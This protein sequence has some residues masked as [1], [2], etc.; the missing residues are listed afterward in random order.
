MAL[1]SISQGFDGGF[2][3]GFGQ[4]LSGLATL[5]INMAVAD[6]QQRQQV[7]ASK[8]LAEH[9][10]Q[11][12]DELQKRRNM[13]S[14]G[15]L[16]AGARAAGLSPAAALGMTP[17]GSSVANGPMPSATTPQMQAPS[18]LEASQAA[19]TQSQARLN[20]AQAKRVEN[21]NLDTEIEWRTISENLPSFFREV[22]KTAGDRKGYF[23]NLADDIQ[24]NGTTTG[25]LR[26]Y[27]ESVVKLPEDIQA[28]LR[29]KGLNELELSKFKLLMSEQGKKLYSAY[30]RKDFDAQRKLYSDIKLIN[31]EIAANKGR[32][33]LMSDQGKEALAAAA[34]FLA[35]ANLI[36]SGDYQTALKEGRLWDFLTIMLGTFSNSAVSTGGQ[37]ASAVVTKN[38]SRA[39]GRLKGRLARG[40]K[41]AQRQTQFVQNKVN[42]DRLDHMRTMDDLYR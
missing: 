3:Q 39:T 40:E 5:P 38:P 2:G 31:S 17:S 34:K 18:V 24:A 41:S 1:E 9:N 6:R 26:G 22:A 14:M 30:V 25:A 19:L 42:Q 21:E 16:V 35:E 13:N 28:S 37:V 8:E 29:N 7:R 20:N 33:D 23:E 4:G 32:I 11:L 36:S 10:M 27:I 15:E 12:S